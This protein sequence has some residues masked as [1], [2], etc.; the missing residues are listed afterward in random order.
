MVSFRQ[1]WC[2]SV[3]WLGWSWSCRA[4]VRPVG[5]VLDWLEW[6][7]TNAELA[8]PVL[9]W[10]CW[11]CSGCTSVGLVVPVSQLCQWEVKEQDHAL[12]QAQQGCVREGTWDALSSSAVHKTLYCFLS[13]E[14]LD[15][16]RSFCHWKS[17]SSSTKA[18]WEQPVFC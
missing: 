17:L 1:T 15:Y 5:L 10:L 11:C 2:K 4:G 7:W 14:G 3:A 16:L 9:D 6:R 13:W 8:G 18:P 12:S